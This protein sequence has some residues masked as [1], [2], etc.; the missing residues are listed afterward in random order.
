M[1]DRRQLVRRER[2]EVGRV[3]ERRRRIRSGDVVADSA[4]IVVGE[5]LFGFARRQTHVVAQVVGEVEPVL[6]GVQAKVGGVGIRR[7]FDVDEESVAAGELLIVVESG[8]DRSVCVLHFLVQLGRG[9]QM[10]VGDV[11]PDGSHRD[12]STAHL[13]SSDPIGGR[14]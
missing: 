5:W 12:P 4:E 3:R 6:L 2:A 8:V 7:E 9:H 11:G 10:R 13:E 14:S 1:F